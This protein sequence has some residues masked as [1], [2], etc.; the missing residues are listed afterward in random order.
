MV[1]FSAE[2]FNFVSFAEKKTKKKSFVLIL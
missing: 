2:K 1:L